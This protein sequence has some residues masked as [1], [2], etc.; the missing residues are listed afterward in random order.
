MA[1]DRLPVPRAARSLLLLGLCFLVSCRTVALAPRSELV[2]QWRCQLRH[3]TCQ[4]VFQENGRFAGYVMEEGVLLS[5]FSGYWSRHG[6]AI[7]YRY[8]DDT[9]GR[10]AKGTTDRDILLQIAKDYFVI[11]AADGSRRRYV[12]NG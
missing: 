10:I 7:L 9:I 1:S 11:Q 12:R 2:G 8:T 3:Q 5:N 6:N 4:Y